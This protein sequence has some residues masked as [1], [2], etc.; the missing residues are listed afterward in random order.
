MR[1]NLK[2]ADSSNRRTLAS[3]TKRPPIL[4]GRLTSS[5]VPQ[6]I[7]WSR[8]A[9][10]SAH[11]LSSLG[12]WTKVTWGIL[13]AKSKQSRTKVASSSFPISALCIRSIIALESISTSALR[14]PLSQ[15][16]RRPSLRLHNF[17]VKL[18]VLPI[19]TVKPTRNCLYRPTT[20]LL[21]SQDPMCAWPIVLI[22][23]LNS[24]IS[25]WFLKH[26]LSQLNYFKIISFNLGSN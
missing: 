24:E 11:C 12:V 6:F 20:T 1:P 15:Q 18:S 9:R 23:S 19:F 5:V 17:A 21:R 25:T 2:L 14:I 7:V 16:S 8:L 3:T 26:S 10:K 4:S 13:E 22:S